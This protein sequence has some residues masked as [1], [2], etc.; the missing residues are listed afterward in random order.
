MALKGFA[1]DAEWSRQ[2]SIAQK[3]HQ[4][5]IAKYEDNLG[6]WFDYSAFCMRNHFGS[7]GEEGFREIISRNPNHVLAL[8]AHGLICLSAEKYEESRTFLEK[9]L[10]LTPKHAIAATVITIMKDSFITIIARESFVN[11]ST[12]ISKLKSFL[13]LRNPSV[14]NE[15]FI[16]PLNLPFKLIVEMWQTRP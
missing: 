10:E 15:T 5:R 6:A 3:Y 4:Q 9:A 11:Q 12:T 8:L 13:I 14:M 1:D 7:I 16:K 2:T